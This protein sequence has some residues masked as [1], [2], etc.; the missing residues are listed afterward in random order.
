MRLY[1]LNYLNVSENISVWIGISYEPDFQS[2]QLG[3][4]RRCTSCAGI[5]GRNQITENF[6]V[7]DDLPWFTPEIQ[8]MLIL[9]VG[10]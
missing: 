6:W 10:L 8:I 3:F 9:K 1:Y 2:K 5:Q 7:L 4:Q